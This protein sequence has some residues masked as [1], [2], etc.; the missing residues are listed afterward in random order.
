M[1][2]SIKGQR[3]LELG[4]GTG[5]LGITA[6]LLGGHVTMTDVA[7][8]LPLLRSNADAHRA[9]ALQA[10]GT[11][12]VALW[13]WA[14]PKTLWRDLPSSHWGHPTPSE[15]DE[16]AERD[17][18]QSMRRNPPSGVPRGPDSKGRARGERRKLSPSGEAFGV[19]L[20]GDLVYS[21]AQVPLLLGVLREVVRRSP[22]AELLLGHKSRSDAVDRALF[23]GLDALGLHVRPVGA[24]RVD[25]AVKVYATRGLA[26]Q[27]QREEACGE[28]AC[29][30]CG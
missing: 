22:A 5:V 23:A 26:K 10:G 15:T 19:I 30:R 4:A 6:A 29:P 14:L 3:V 27:D 13:D 12:T 28:E 9:D 18:S 8:L 7:G 16:D 2:E 21:V 24:S 25:S 20:G 17:G 11:L 1:S